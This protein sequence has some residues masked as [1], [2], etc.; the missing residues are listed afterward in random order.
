MLPLSRHFRVTTLKKLKL[1]PKNLSSLL[2]R[3][4]K[5]STSSRVLRELSQEQTVQQELMPEQPETLV[6]I[7][8]RYAA[9]V[10]HFDDVRLDKMSK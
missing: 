2:T 5:N 8:T 7:Q 10:A 6:Y 3:L 1:K 4:P 9:G